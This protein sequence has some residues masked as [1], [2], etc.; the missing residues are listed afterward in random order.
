MEN[1]TEG[2]QSRWYPIRIGKEVL[3][4]Y[5]AK[6]RRV[7]YSYVAIRMMLGA[8]DVVNALALG[9]VAALAAVVAGAV[10]PT[11]VLADLLA[12]IG[13]P[14]QALRIIGIV[15]IFLFATKGFAEYFFRKRMLLFIA[16]REFQISA[17]L[18]Q[19]FLR[20]P[21]C[22]I[23]SWGNV[24][25]AFSVGQGVAGGSLVLGA[26][27]SA[28]SEAL[29][30]VI[31]AGLLF[32][33]NPIAAMCAL[34][35]MGLLAF[36]L[37]RYSSPRL[38]SN[39]AAINQSAVASQET[40]QEGL[41]AYREINTAGRVP[42]IISRYT[43]FRSEG[44]LATGRQIV[45]SQV[46]SLILQYGIF[47]GI[48]AFT[49]TLFWDGGGP[50]SFATLAIF[51]SAGSR[52]AGA[53][54]PLQNS[55]NIAISAVPQAE[56]MLK[57]TR[58]LEEHETKS[59]STDLKVS[60]SNRNDFVPAI[61]FRN[62][63]FTYP[64]AEKSALRNVSFTAPA[65]SMIAIAGASGSGK[66]TMVDLLLGMNE[67]ESGSIEI[68]GQ[69]PRAV[70]VEWPGILGYVPQSVYAADRTLAENVALGFD[71]EDIDEAQVW[72]ALE[73]AQLDVLVKS[74]P[75][76]LETKMGDLGS[77]MS[78]GQQQR[79]G[80]ARALYTEPSILVL[81]EATSAL[82]AETEAAITSTLESLR[83]KMT[84]VVIAHR[85]STVQ[86]ADQVLLLEE[87]SCLGAGTFTEMR[88]RFP[89][90]DRQ[91]K[92]LGL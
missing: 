90:F 62:V 57:L 23:Q 20:L 4:Y 80:L 87:G 37:Q 29:V 40:F 36:G 16:K 83:T 2:T 17:E 27:S 77:R 22:K 24:D 73:Q 38:L 92:L 33:F 72:K 28:L 69:M 89:Q 13:D 21:L 60:I 34:L 1:I 3:H 76:Q 25:A 30:L 74:W 88:N 75:E 71:R 26:I 14:L 59:V 78:G 6:S 81:D 63:S 31:M 46:P 91:A 85:L 43:N 82:D 42:W 58:W 51:G 44:S 65:F 66:S 55:W 49:I 18:V 64:G 9:A 45:T 47:I 32:A 5:P 67:P 68:G 61:E 79:L 70:R 86:K 54:G 56:R 19:R 48:A 52:M 39:T 35:V 10:A 50:Q 15:A 12:R 11:G 7:Y 41:F 53:V 84:L 8:F